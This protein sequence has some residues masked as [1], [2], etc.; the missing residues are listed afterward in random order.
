MKTAA[1][2]EIY[3]RQTQNVLGAQGISQFFLK[4]MG[5]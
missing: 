4:T 1:F 2:D 5:A 3:F